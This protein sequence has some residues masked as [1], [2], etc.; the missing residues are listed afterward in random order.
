MHAII[1]AA[2]RGNRL[3]EFNP[4]GRPKC[5]LEFG[6]RTLLDR[7][8]DILF[9]LGVGR[10]TL[11]VGYEADLVIDHVGTLASRPEVAFVYNPAYL[12]GSVLSLLAAREIMTGGEPVLVMDAD[13]LFHPGILKRLVASPNKNCFLIDR[14]FAAGDEPV[15]IALHRGQMV[16]FR[17]ALPADLAFD[18]LGESVGFFKFDPEV[19]A[20]ISRIC[21]AY[22]TDGMSDAPHE[23]A[24]RDVL[25]SMASEF[26]CEDVSDLPWLEIDFPEDIE[27]AIKRVLPA[28]RRDF[29]DF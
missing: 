15:K 24:L 19:A 4:D 8:L 7:Q 2:G 26:A 20:E 27:R 9:R 14:D 10:V 18:T 13:V 23:E 16:E 12:K 28:I 29:A 5:L 1:L 6:G 17:K 25:L 3:A 11:V 21:A 22:D